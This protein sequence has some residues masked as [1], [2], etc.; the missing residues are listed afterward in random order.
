MK[1]TL[2]L[3]LAALLA[4]TTFSMV[5][6]AADDAAEPIVFTFINADGSIPEGT[7]RNGKCYFPNAE[8]ATDMENPEVYTWNTA[9]MNAE[10]GFAVFYPGSGSSMMEV[11]SFPK[12]HAWSADKKLTF[13]KIAM[14]ASAANNTTINLVAQGNKYKKTFEVAF[15]GEWQDIIFDLNDA[16][17]WT[18]KSDTGFYE[19]IDYSPMKNADGKQVMVGGYRIDFPSKTVSDKLIIDYIGIFASEEDAKKYTGREKAA[20]TMTVTGHIEGFGTGSS[21]PSSSSSSSSS[22]STTTKEPEKPK[23]K[24]AVKRFKKA[25]QGEFKAAVEAVADDNKVIYRFADMSEMNSEKK[26]MI[27][28]GIM[29]H[30]ITWGQGTVANGQGGT[31][32][33]TCAAGGGNLFECQTK[34]TP[35]AKT[36]KYLVVGMRSETDL[37]SGSTTT[38]YSSGNKFRASLPLK[39]DGAWHYDVFDISQLDWEELGDDK[40][41]T[42]ADADSV[43]SRIAFAAYRFDFPKVNGAVYEIDFIGFFDSEE[44]AKATAEKGMNAAKEAMGTDKEEEKFTYMKGYDDNTFRPEANMSRA[45]AATVIARLLADE[46]TIAADRDTKFTDV[47]KGEWYY[48]YVTYLEELGFLPNYSGTFEPNKNITRGEFVKLAYEAG[49]FEFSNKRP[50]FIDVDAKNPFYKEIAVASAS[51][52]IKG[53]SEPDGK[54]SFRPNGEITRAEIATIVNRILGIED[55]KAA[56]ARFTD[57]DATHWAYGTIMAIVPEK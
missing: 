10:D 25:Q 8:K 52:V 45:E 38:F 51:G 27:D 48:G 32:V 42:A 57:L 50:D 5:S 19:P 22:S 44:E 3:V 4:L 1:K 14:K 11:D 33:L 16:T 46:E 24:D 6:F 31:A 20:S 34:T 49:G 21:A 23:M 47:K 2:A 15:T 28:D 29:V 30:V 43:M 40:N 53:Y 55:D 12:A 56:K 18:I 13:I 9:S 36:M 54:K 39:T 35:K 7:G 17:G 26:Y 41:Y 37:Q